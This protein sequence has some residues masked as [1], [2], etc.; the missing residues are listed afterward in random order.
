MADGPD[1]VAS[2]DRAPADRPT[3]ASRV[4][5]VVGR[6]LIWVGML[7]LGYVGYQLWGTGLNEAREQDQLA[8][9][10]ESP[11]PPNSIPDYGDAVGRI[12]IP[13]LDVDKVIV[14]GVDWKSLKKGPGLFPN[15]PLPCQLG[16]VSLAGHRTTFGAPFER[17]NELKAGDAIT[18]ETPT[19]E[20]TY[21]VK[22]DPTIVPPTAVEIL[23]TTDPNVGMLTLVSCHPKWTASKR[24]VVVAQMTPA[25]TPQSATPFVPTSTVEPA[26]TGGWFHD[27]A[28][29]PWV[30]L[31]GLAVAL[32]VKWRRMMLARRYRKSFSAIV[33]SPFFF[34]SLFFFYENVARLVPT[35]L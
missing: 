20:C 9:V 35:S 22:G 21:T 23:R 6:S 13:S 32:V 16:N 14:A 33:L 5:D 31:Y 26:F 10:L 8:R 2:P 24:I 11:R 27:P 17:I 29:W 12:S 25:A 34:V 18:I 30:L 1:I 28:G 15:S 3:T 7:M 19:G 4:L